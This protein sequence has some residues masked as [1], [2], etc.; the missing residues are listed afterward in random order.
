[1]EELLYK[2]KFLKRAIGRLNRIAGH[3]K[4]DPQ[5]GCTN[6]I[7]D[8]HIYFLVHAYKLLWEFI[9]MYL[10]VFEDIAADSPESCFREILSLG[11]VTPEETTKLLKLIDLCNNTTNISN[12]KLDNYVFEQIPEYSKLL[13]KV[14]STFRDRLYSYLILYHN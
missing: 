4:N 6:F 10:K 3:L 9:S 14:F 1:M 5:K 7:R 13:D 12:N 8:I 2:F 11:I